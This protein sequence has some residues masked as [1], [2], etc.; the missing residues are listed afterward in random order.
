MGAV[1]TFTSQRLRDN[2][3]LFNVRM[4]EIAG[5]NFKM[6]LLTNH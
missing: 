5:L 6:V 4:E 1:N 3:L 2:T